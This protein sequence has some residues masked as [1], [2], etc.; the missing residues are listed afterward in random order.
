MLKIREHIYVE[1]VM[2]NDPEDHKGSRENLSWS[3]TTN[4]KRYYISEMDP[5]YIV[6]AINKIK[7]YSYGT[8]DQ[9]KDGVPLQEWIHYFEDELIYTNNSKLLINV[10]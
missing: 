2:H 1:K 6:N 4:G 10:E 7:R 9:K 8:F 3:S 5:N